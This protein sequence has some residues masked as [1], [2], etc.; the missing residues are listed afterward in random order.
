MKS[1]CGC[2]KLRFVTTY[3]KNGGEKKSKRVFRSGGVGL[4]S[5]VVLRRRVSP[6]LRGLTFFVV[7]DYY[8]YFTSFF[9]L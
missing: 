2:V 5:D 4:L 1:G 8:P 9:I 6:R 3:K 7:F